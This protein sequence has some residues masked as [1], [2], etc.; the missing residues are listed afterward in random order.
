MPTLA[1]FL[2][3][4][5]LYAESLA[6]YELFHAFTR[7]LIDEKCHTKADGYDLSAFPNARGALSATR[8]SLVS[9]LWEAVAKIAVYTES[10]KECDCYQETDIVQLVTYMT[11]FRSLEPFPKGLHDGTWKTD[12]KP[13]M[14]MIETQL[15]SLAPV[16]KRPPASGPGPQCNFCG[17]F[18]HKISEC[19]NKDEP[20]M[21]NKNHKKAHREARITSG[22]GKKK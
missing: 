12:N 14:Q 4:V 9:Y 10:L 22:A 8:G 15:R 17:G 21:T 1:K 7:Y 5:R 11:P 16:S 6:E 2:P 13:H 20:R 18:G 19:P 3:T